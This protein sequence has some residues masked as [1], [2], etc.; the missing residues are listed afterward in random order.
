MQHKSFSNI[1]L[2]FELFTSRSTDPRFLDSSNIEAARAKT[3]KCGS[4]STVWIRTPHLPSQEKLRKQQPR[5]Q[6]PQSLLAC[7]GHSQSEDQYPTKQSMCAKSRA[8][9]NHLQ[10]MPSRKGVVF[11]KSLDPYSCLTLSADPQAP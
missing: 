5:P 6:E 10:T 4:V 9:Q 2:C 3:T 7:L 8:P 11:S 1:F